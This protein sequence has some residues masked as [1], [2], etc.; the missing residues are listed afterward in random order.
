MCSKRGLRLVRRL[1][2]R[3]DDDDED[4]SLWRLSRGSSSGSATAGTVASP[5]PDPFDSGVPESTDSVLRAA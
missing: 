4:E 1:R 2:P 3:L 5:E